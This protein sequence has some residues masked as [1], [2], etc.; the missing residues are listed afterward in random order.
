[1]NEYYALCGGGALA[2]PLMKKSHATTVAFV[3]GK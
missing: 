2:F 1:M 3:L